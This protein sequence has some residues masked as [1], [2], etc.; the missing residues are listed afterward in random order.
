MNTV[1]SKGGAAGLG[2]GLAP[3]GVGP[4]VVMGAEVP[5]IC[6]RPGGC[7]VVRQSH[8]VTG[9]LCLGDLEGCRNDLKDRIF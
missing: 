7:L 2:G 4:A 8:Q 5:G 3:A 1:P 9:R 6:R